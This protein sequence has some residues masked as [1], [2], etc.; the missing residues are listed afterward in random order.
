MWGDLNVFC[1]WVFLECSLW[2]CAMAHCF[3]LLCKNKLDIPK[4][5]LTLFAVAS[6]WHFLLVFADK[7]VACYGGGLLVLLA[8]TEEKRTQ[9][10]LTNTTVFSGTNYYTKYYV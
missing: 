7:K 4:V 10:E 6:K 5:F 3:G 1:F 9:A 8:T 2:S